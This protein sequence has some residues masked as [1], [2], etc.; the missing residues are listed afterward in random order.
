MP[1]ALKCLLTP[2]TYVCAIVECYIRRKLHQRFIRWVCLSSFTHLKLLIEH[3]L[4]AKNCS[5]DSVFFFF[6][7]LTSP[8][9]CPFLGLWIFML[10]PSQNIWIPAPWQQNLFSFYFFSV[11]TCPWPTFSRWHISKNSFLYLSIM[12]TFLIFL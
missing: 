1:K 11:K 12:K 9:V 10:L 2:T 4:C 7:F 3:L 6:F 8:G 5:G